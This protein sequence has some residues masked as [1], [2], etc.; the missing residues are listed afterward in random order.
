MDTE[1]HAA[2]GDPGRL[3]RFAAQTPM[4]RAGRPEE[5][6]SAILWLL[7]DAAS[8]STGAILAVSGGR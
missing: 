8:Y 5:A 4:R 3:Q 2:A 6:A 7:S 1:L